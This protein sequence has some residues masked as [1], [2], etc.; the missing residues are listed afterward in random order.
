ML[1]IK[2]GKN[3]GIDRAL[4]RFKRKFRETQMIKILRD[5]KHY[6]KKS[7]EKRVL[8]QK[9]IYNRIKKESYDE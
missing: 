9:S 7:E 2:I 8:K 6:T 1:I 4:K 5:K 3:E